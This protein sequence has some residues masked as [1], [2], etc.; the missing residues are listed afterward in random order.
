MHV[1]IM[2]DSTFLS[3]YIVQ[4]VHKTTTV[5][6]TILT[7]LILPKGTLVVSAQEKTGWR[8]NWEKTVEAARKEGQ[9]NVY[10]A[11]WGAVLNAGVFQRAYPKIKLVGVT[12][13]RGA[14]LEQRI[15]SERRAGK[16]IADV[17]ST[18]SRTMHGFYKG[19][20]LDPIRPALILPE[21]NDESRW[22]QEKHRYVDHERQ[23]M[24]RYAY[25]PNTGAV[26]YNTKLVDPKQFKSLW[27][28]LDP[29]WKGKI[30]ASD[31]ELGG[32]A[33]AAMRLYYNNPDLGPK[34][35]TRLFS[36]MDITLFRG[37]RQGPNWLAV[38]KFAICFLCSG[39]EIDRAKSQGLP[40]ERIGTLKEGAGLTSRQGITG[41]MNRAPHPNA[42]K[43]FINWFLSR[44]GRAALMRA[45]AKTGISV[46]YSL[47][48]DIP[49]DDVP[50]W[51]RLIEG[52][53]YVELDVPGQM[54]M[55]PILKIYR[56]AKAKKK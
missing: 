2:G 28:F 27:D 23:Y 54:E 49:K 40:V 52:V 6:F 5:I 45:L 26:F 13:G 9:V 12:A 25:V 16:H 8:V 37:R 29:K 51:N 19:G 4:L 44:E 53:N 31:P 32:S 24:F 14:Q 33:N 56:K 42:A 38:G 21:V 15:W 46:P 7:F 3:K 34:F 39:G 50:P 11:D 41:I 36:E 17:V 35:I 18:G 43:V 48:T 55:E 47:R 10:I 20:A 1:L 30:T 22:W